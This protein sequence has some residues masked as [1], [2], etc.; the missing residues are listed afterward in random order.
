MLGVVYG[1][2]CV[3]YYGCVLPGDDSH[4][5]QLKDFGQDDDKI[6]GAEWVSSPDQT[7]MWALEP[8]V[9]KS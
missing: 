7:E 2:Q 8:A 9:F 4:C 6:K 5:S 3:R 1:L